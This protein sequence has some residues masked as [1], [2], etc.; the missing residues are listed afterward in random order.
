MMFEQLYTLLQ[1][2]RDAVRQLSDCLEQERQALAELDTKALEAAAETKQRLLQTL[3]REAEERTRLATQAGYDHA[4]MEA[5]LA[6]V[7]RQGQLQ[8]GW[9]DL[10]DGLRACQHQNRVNGGVIELGRE[11]LHLALGLLRGQ[12]TGPRA[13][14]YQA[15]GR[16]PT[17]LDHRALGTA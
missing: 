9:Q 16:T 4:S 6:S 3:E 15:N 14:L 10:L 1:K 5:Y 11:R 12:G 7:D 17:S 8:N 2:E 13:N